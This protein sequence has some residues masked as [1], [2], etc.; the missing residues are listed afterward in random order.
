MEVA[1][2][3]HCKK[4]SSSSSSEEECESYYHLDRSV[5]S[6]NLSWEQELRS[7]AAPGAFVPA[8][9]GNEEGPGKLT[10]TLKLWFNELLSSGKYELTIYD[11]NPI[12]ENLVSAT[13]DSGSSAVNGP[14]VVR[15]FSPD[16]PP[17]FKVR[18]NKK[19]LTGLIR[20]NNIITFLS[21]SPNFA[22]VGSVASLVQAINNGLLYINVTTSKNP[23]GAIRG[24]LG[25]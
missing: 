12:Q 6:T 10:G 5:F 23:E 21:T 16:H 19:V 13:I 3:K 9:N 25:L 2:V 8:S 4:S 14:I 7:N 20:N 22:S 1:R 24:Q 18:N 15:L 11:K 17:K